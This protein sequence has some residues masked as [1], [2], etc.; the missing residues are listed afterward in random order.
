[1]NLKKKNCYIEYFLG[2]IEIQVMSLTNNIKRLNIHKKNNKKDFNAIKS[3]I[4]FVNKRKKL[5]YYL[6][7]NDLQTFNNLLKVLNM[8]KI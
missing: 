5:L 1:M 4:N 7:N 2:T 6:R 8:K 3:L